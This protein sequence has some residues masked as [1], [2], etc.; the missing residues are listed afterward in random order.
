MPSFRNRIIDDY[1]PNEF[2]AVKLYESLQN[3]EDFNKFAR[4]ILEWILKK[5]DQSVG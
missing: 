1:L 4:Y 5:D 2:D 3:L